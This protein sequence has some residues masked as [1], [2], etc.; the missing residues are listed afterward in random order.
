[1]LTIRLHRIG[2][3]NQPSFKVVVIDKRKSAA[4]GSFIE[5][6]GH[7]NRLTKQTKLNSERLAYWLKVG[8][9]PSASVHNLLVT[10]KVISAKKIAKQA[11][12][13]K[14]APKDVVSPQTPQTAQPATS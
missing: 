11:K 2:K 7:V 14:T 12:S 13:K 6:V 10:Q 1:M 9:K 3:T 8:A 4:S 5:E